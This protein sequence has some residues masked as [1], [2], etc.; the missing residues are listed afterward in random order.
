MELAGFFKM[1]ILT[2]KYIWCQNTEDCIL[3]LKVGTLLD[4]D[5]VIVV[6]STCEI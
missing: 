1:K 3:N 6:Y 2:Y 5:T 4:A